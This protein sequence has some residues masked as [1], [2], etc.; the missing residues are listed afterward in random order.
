MCRKIIMYEL[1]LVS[2]RHSGWG[3]W[4]KNWFRVHMMCRAGMS[5]LN[6]WL[7]PGMALRENKLGL[8][9]SGANQPVNLP[10]PY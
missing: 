2:C 4:C 6:P 8:T 9:L 3:K 10:S 5:S 1:M 7:I